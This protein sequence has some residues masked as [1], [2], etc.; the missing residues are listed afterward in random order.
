[1]KRDGIETHGRAA[2][3]SNMGP[4]GGRSGGARISG[5]APPSVEEK[6]RDEES[7]VGVGPHRRS[8]LDGRPPGVLLDPPPSRV[9]CQQDTVKRWRRAVRQVSGMDGF[10]GAL[11]SVG[12][13][14][15]SVAGDRAPGGG[16][17]V[18][19]ASVSTPIARRWQRAALIVLAL[20]TIGGQQIWPPVQT[21]AAQSGPSWTLAR[22]HVFAPRPPTLSPALQARPG[23]GS[24]GP[25]P[26]LSTTHAGPTAHLP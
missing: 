5:G 17:N 11:A 14:R 18:R 6:G 21:A 24:V 13:S 25:V 1:M 19:L 23:V 16:G 20:A 12:M 10:H 3:S 15:R 2:A 9:G 8:R 26:S 22:P 7:L 4:A